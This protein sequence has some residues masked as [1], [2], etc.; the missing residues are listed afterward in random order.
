MKKEKER[1]KRKTVYI[2]AVMHGRILVSGRAVTLSPPIH[3]K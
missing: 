3:S 2:G 1:E